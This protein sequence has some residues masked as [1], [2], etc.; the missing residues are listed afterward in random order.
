V[1]VEV[2][3]KP[4]GTSPAVIAVKKDSGKIKLF[5]GNVEYAV[6]LVYKVEEGGISVK[7][8]A[9]PWAIAK[10]NGLSLGKTPQSVKAEQRHRF[11]LMRPNERAPLVVSLLWNP[12]NG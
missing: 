1:N 10:H 9:N 3:G 8:D 2:D 4:L 7:L 6:T 12:K 5:G 11:S